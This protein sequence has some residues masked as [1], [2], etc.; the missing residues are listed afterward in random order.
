MAPCFKHQGKDENI[1]I[2]SMVRND[3]VNIKCEQNVSINVACVSVFVK[4]RHLQ[5]WL[6]CRNDFSVCIVDMLITLTV[7]NPS[8]TCLL[9][10]FFVF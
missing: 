7:N 8:N 9:L 2:S 1:T 3:L 6:F 5:L 4:I 10:P